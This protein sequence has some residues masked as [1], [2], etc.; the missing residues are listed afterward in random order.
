MKRL[1]TLLP[2]I[3]FALIASAADGD[4]KK[5]TVDGIEWTYNVVSETDKSCDLGGYT[6]NDAG[7][8][9]YYPAI[10]VNITGALSIP[11]T[12][13]GYTVGSI[14]IECFRGCKITSVTI[15]EGV[16]TL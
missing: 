7:D 2:L 11:S 10:D 1:F 13:D 14:G 4:V 9:V 6:S 8:A 3:L 16:T 12:L 15:P 5:T